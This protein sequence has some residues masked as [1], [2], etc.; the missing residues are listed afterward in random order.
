MGLV[1]RLPLLL[2]I[3]VAALAWPA[4]AMAAA[5]SL[6][7]C[8]DP[9]NFKGCTL[10]YTADA[11]EPNSAVMNTSTFGGS[12]YEVHDP[13]VVEIRPTSPCFQGPDNQ[14]ME[15][16]QDDVTSFA[17]SLG[18]G[19]DKI[20]VLANLPTSIGAGDGSDTMVGGPAA[21]FLRGGQGSDAI[22]GSA[23]NDQLVGDDPGQP[24]GGDDDLNGAGG[25][26]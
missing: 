7:N 11:G 15:C 21:D 20:T 16:P 18:D 23:G 26:D 1:G 19:N 17:A 24:G 5:G 10:N 6:T 2:A 12:T 13:G 9:V 4:A 25:S 8:A 22:D 14:T 3:S